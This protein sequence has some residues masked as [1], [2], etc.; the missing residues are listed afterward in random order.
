MTTPA[1]MPWKLL[2][3]PDIRGFIRAHESTD[4]RELALKKPPGNDWPLPLVLDQIKARQKAA[5]KNPQWLEAP[6]VIFP[7]TIFMEQAS[8][9]ATARYKA[10]LAHGK[11]FADLTGG[12]GVDTLAMS[13]NFESGI[14]IE[15]DAQAA[16]LI[17]HNLKLLGKNPVAVHHAQAENFE[18]IIAGTVDVLCIDPQRRDDTRKGFYR[19]ADCSPDITALLP[20]MKEK[21]R[22]AIIKTSPMLDIAQTLQTLEYVAQV[23]VLEWRGDCK[24]VVYVLD[25]SGRTNPDDVPVTAVMLGDNGAPLAQTTHT[26]MQETQVNAEISP[27]LAYL[28]EPGPAFQKAGGFNTMAQNFDV[29]K[30][31]RNTHLYTADAPVPG[32]PGRGFAVQGVFPAS[33]KAL[34]FSQ[35]NLTLRNFPG[36]TAALRKKLGL[37]DGGEDY[38]FA[39]TLQDESKA[40]IHARKIS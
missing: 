22:A 37:K 4:V 5:E 7:A 35:A 26:R 13:E 31:H 38:V 30:L 23:H 24:E 29:K 9:T 40:L 27:P 36:D 1:N 32:F 10:S 3:R 11:T 33:G 20:K 17:D 14:C 39:C 25:F 21:A 8:S 6:D 18:E 16:S 15:R 28:Y 34:P 12:C 2:L 19:L